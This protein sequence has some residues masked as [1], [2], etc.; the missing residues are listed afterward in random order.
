MTQA[1]HDPLYRRHRSAAEVIAHAVWLSLRFP[2]GLRLVE[3]LL[4]A[5]RIVA[6][7]G[8]TRLREIETMHAA[9]GE[10]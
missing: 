1:A 4:S 5:H 3:D 8:R 7:S 6:A 10:I 2:L 9:L